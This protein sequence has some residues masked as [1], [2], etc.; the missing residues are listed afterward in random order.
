MLEHEAIEYAQLLDDAVRGRWVTLRCRDMRS[1]RRHLRALCEL[2]DAMG[3][4]YRAYHAIGSEHIVIGD[5]LRDGGIDFEVEG[6]MPHPG[7]PRLA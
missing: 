3:L 4:A 2:A 1:V 7:D 6:R 5:N